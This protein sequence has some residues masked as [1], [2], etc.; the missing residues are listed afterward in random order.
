MTVIGARS[1]FRKRRQKVLK[2]LQLA[3]VGEFWH[4]NLT[5]HP[6]QRGLKRWEAPIDA[7]WRTPSTS[8]NTGLIAAMDLGG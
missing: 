5:D 4:T 6:T 8:V 2:L 3:T 7:H 1:S